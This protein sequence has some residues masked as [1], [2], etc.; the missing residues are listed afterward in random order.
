MSRYDIVVWDFNG[1]LLDDKEI[2]R[3][4]IN[5][6]LKSYDLPLLSS[7]KYGELFC[8]PIEK[9]Y[10]ATGITA[11]ESFTSLAQK[12][13]IAY[14][15]AR[16]EIKCFDD[17]EEVLKILKNK[18]IQQT[19]ISATI[20]EGLIAHLKYLGISD[21]FKEI[22]GLADIYA[23]GKADIALKW[24]KDNN[25]QNKRILLVG[26]CDHDYE[27]AQLLNADCVLIA[28]GHMAREKLEKIDVPIFDD[29]RRLIAYV[30]DN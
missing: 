11:Y 25:Y 26:D 2:C 17:I 13:A 23:A 28:R 3:G 1:T 19:V 20:Q 16:P 21:Y 24:L 22:L 7:E 14:R 30:D 4:I 18:G 12:Y 29:A 9:Y 6:M 27:I 15:A 10:E 5:D 8:F